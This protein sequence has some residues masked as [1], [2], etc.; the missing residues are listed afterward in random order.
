MQNLPFKKSK[1][2]GSVVSAADNAPIIGA[3]VV[4]KGTTSGTVTDFDGN[5]TIEAGASDVLVFSFVGYK[6]QEVTVGNRSNIR[7]LLEEEVT[8]LDEVVV[9][10]YGVQKKKLN[11]GSTVSVKGEEIARQNTVSPMTALQGHTPGVSILK[12]TGEPGAGF[13]VNIRGMGTIG[14]SQPLYVIDGVP[15]G[16]IDYLAPSDI[17]SI[18]VLKDAASA[19]IYGSRAA[20]GVILVTTKK[21]KAIGAGSNPIKA[22]ITYDGYY[23]WQNL[24]KKLPVANAQEY[25]VLLNEAR[26]NSGQPLLDFA[27]LVPDWEKIQNGSWKGTDWIDELTVKDAPIQNHAVNIFGG[28]DLS[29]YSLGLS[30]AGQDGI[31][32]KPVASQYDRYTMRLNTD[33]TLIRNK[34]NNMDILKVGE[35]LRYSYSTRHGIGTGNQ[36]WNDVFSSVV[37]S[38]FLPMYATDEADLAYPYHYAIDWNPQE[39]SPIA[40]MVYN[41]GLNESKNYNLDGSIYAE[42]QPIRNLRYKS[43]FGYRMSA[44]S[45]RSYNPVYKLSATSF[46]NN[47]RVNHNMSAG[48]SWTW[49]NTLAYDFQLNSVHN[50]NLLAG[51]SAEK[52]GLGENISGENIKSLFSDFEHAFLDN[53]PIINA[54]GTT[55]LGSSPWGEGGILS[56]FGRVSYSYK[57]KYMATAIVRADGSSNFA[58]DKRWGIFPS[59]S[60]GWVIS[61]ENFLKDKIS[62]LDFLKLRASWGQNGNQAIS[63]FQYLATISFENVNY[64]FGP[65]KGSVFTGGYPN[66]LPNPDVTWETSDQ[67]SVGLDARMFN[68][69]MSLTFD[70]YNKQT[71]DWLVNPSALASYGTNAPYINGGDVSNKGIE[72]GL[73]WGDKIGEFSYNINANLAYNTNEVT[74]IAN[75][76]G[77]FHGPGNVLGQGTEE[78]YRAQVGYPIGYFW[79]YKTNGV[80]QNAQEVQAYKN[81]DGQV[82]MPNAVP[83][84]LIFNDTNDDGQITS[85]DKVMIGD[86][87][88]DYIVGLNLVLEYKGFDFTLM[89]NGALGHQIARSWRRWADSPQNNYTTDVF[90]RWHGEGSSNKYPR[91]SYGAHPN[92][93]Y[94]SDIFIEDADYLRISNLTLGYDLK[95]AIKAIPLA[96]TRIYITAQNLYTFSKYSG[97]DPEIGTSTTSDNWA[98][99]IDVGYYPAPRTVLVGVSLKF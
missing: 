50:F 59:I 15:G 85:D 23:G 7:V 30:Y 33:F 35:T 5:F 42:I 36:Y 53:T 97:M 71:K 95:K 63:A 76:E 67:V 43:S 46:R 70:V 13:K 52:W 48:Y 86:P 90:A 27:G 29:V 89:A 9:I 79:G 10:G 45:Y 32:G 60:A 16:N 28:S 77:I 75:N 4:L 41:R 20:N 47:D 58:P 72:L 17:E 6:T 55:K 34:S 83:G 73:G 87:N 84:D 26:V 94:N 78:L 37:A 2:T 81:S 92:W 91:L 44:S 80:F 82:I 74:H 49:E 57:E 96:Q 25:A 64:F 8:D 38:P 56:Y 93:Q 11:T 22:N 31:F 51:M 68:S 21:G 66:I 54:D 99:G 24:Y 19:A 88:P 65:N 14:N 69:R 12:T 98:K 62:A 18:D 1:V 40:S 61:E 39:A 3:T